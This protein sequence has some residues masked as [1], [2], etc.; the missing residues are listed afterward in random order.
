MAANP[1]SKFERD[2][3]AAEA[4]RQSR[5]HREHE[6]RGRPG[7]RDDRVPDRPVAQV[8]GVDRRRLRPAEAA[9]GDR[10]DDEECR[11]DRVEVDDRVQRES[12][13]QLRG[14]VPESI[15]GQGMGEL[16]DRERHEEDECDR[17][18]QL[19][20]YVDLHAGLRWRT[21]VSIVPRAHVPTRPTAHR[22]PAHREAAHRESRATGGRAARPS[23]PRTP[24]G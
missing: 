19:G 20:G 17:D 14:S 3:T 24:R 10:R 8:R 4:E 15:R 13:E 21:G 1:A 16:V 22:P 18:D 11:T 12:P 5:C 9:S 2:R 7:E 23:S 6:I